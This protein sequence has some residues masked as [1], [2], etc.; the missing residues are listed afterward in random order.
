MKAKRPKKFFRQEEG[1]P[2][3]LTLTLT[4]PPL[5]A[6]LSDEDYQARVQ[7]LVESETLRFRAERKKA[8]KRQA[9]SHAAN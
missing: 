4:K 9:L 8:G 2:E 7:R 3:E 5:F 6:N 1:L